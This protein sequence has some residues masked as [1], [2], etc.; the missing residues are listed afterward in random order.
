[1]RSAERMTPSLSSKPSTSPRGS[2]SITQESTR[3]STCGRK[4]HTSV[5][6]STGSIGT[7]RSGK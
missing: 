7:A 4:L 3:R 2:I 6:S 5:E 1:M